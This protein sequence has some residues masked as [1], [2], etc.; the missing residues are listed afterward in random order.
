MKKIIKS[1]KHSWINRRYTIYATLD[2]YNLWN[3]WNVYKQIDK[4]K[5]HGRYRILKAILGAVFD[6]SSTW[7]TLYTKYAES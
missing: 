3:K 7:N 6:I 2:I 4:Y 1:R 5:Y